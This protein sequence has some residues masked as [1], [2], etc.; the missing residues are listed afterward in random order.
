MDA[1]RIV[2]RNVRVGILL[3]KKK[4]IEHT[5]LETKW[6]RDRSQPIEIGHHSLPIRH[7][8]LLIFEYKLPSIENQSMHLMALIPRVKTFCSFNWTRPFGPHEITKAPWL[9]PCCKQRSKMPCETKNILNWMPSK[10][11]SISPTLRRHLPSLIF[12]QIVSEKRRKK[13]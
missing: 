9:H 3:T 1:E 6:P 7:P 8:R 4:A 13:R 5:L 2:Q 11:R 10:L 12:S